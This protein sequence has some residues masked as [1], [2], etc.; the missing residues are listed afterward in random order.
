MKQTMDNNISNQNK[1]ENQQ[2]TQDLAIRI[3]SIMAFNEFKLTTLI[4]HHIIDW[5]FL[6]NNRFISKKT[7]EIEAKKTFDEYKKSGFIDA[8]NNMREDLLEC[9]Q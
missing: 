7:A 4:E 2:L 8:W 3:M 1:I 5:E 9:L 6:N